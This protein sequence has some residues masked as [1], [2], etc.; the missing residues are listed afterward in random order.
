M[1]FLLNVN[2]PKYVPLKL[3]FRKPIKESFDKALYLL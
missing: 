1:I 3:N 2:H